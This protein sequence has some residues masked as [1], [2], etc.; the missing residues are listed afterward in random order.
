MPAQLPQELLDI[1]IGHVHNKPTLQSC[2]LTSSRLRTP[3]QRGLFSSF[4]ISLAI[5]YRV[6]NDRFLQFTRF[7][8]YVKTL[9]VVFPSGLSPAAA[10]ADVSALRSLLDRLERVRQCTLDS[11]GWALS[12]TIWGSPFCATIL[13]FIQ[14][15]NLLE[16]HIRSII[17]IPCETLAAF[18]CATPMLGLH[19]AS[20][21]C[22]WVLPQSEY[23]DVK[24]EHLRL[25]GCGM[26]LDAL[27]QGPFAPLTAN[28]RRMWTT[29]GT[30][31]RTF[32]FAPGL[33]ARLE[34]LRVDWPSA[35][36][37]PM[38]PTEL[39][40]ALRTLDLS[41]RSFDRDVKPAQVAIFAPL[42][43]C[44]TT[45]LAE[46]RFSYSLGKNVFRKYFHTDTLEAVA[47]ALEK[48][49]GTPRISWY[50]SVEGSKSRREHQLMKFTALLQAGLPCVHEQ[51]RLYVQNRAFAD[52]WSDSV[53]TP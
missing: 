22:N 13:D 38:D 46:I 39:F 47:A 35:P 50:I 21:I 9:T 37:Q 49:P 48:C 34:Y 42:F 27:Q 2:A 4:R 6:A 45:A 28:V 31:N 12:P 24:A 44:T 1:I 15:Q 41:P 23:P 11:A 26:V 8:G 25:T 10:A 14:R 36:E 29:M 30:Y 51:G 43:S 5:P 53:T 16:L 32:K 52:D 7:A 20:V 33:A 18:F 19:N 40:A 17:D 3:S